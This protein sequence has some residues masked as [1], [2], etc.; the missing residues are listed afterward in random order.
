MLIQINQNITHAPHATNTTSVWI[1][2]PP[3]EEGKLVDMMFL[4]LL[5]A[6]LPVVTPTATRGR[7][8][9]HLKVQISLLLLYCWF[10]F[11]L[12][13]TVVDCCRFIVRVVQCYGGYR[14]LLVKEVEGVEFV[15]SSLVGDKED[16]E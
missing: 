6:P 16:E 8:T 1:H 10:L 5:F 9:G 15:A 2:A 11:M 3:L 13:S 4:N 14:G 7:R 12:S